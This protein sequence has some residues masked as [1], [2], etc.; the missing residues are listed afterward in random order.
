MV[1]VF[2]GNGVAGYTSLA[3]IDRPTVILG[4]VGQKCGVV[5]RNDGPAWIT[6][7]ALYARRFK[8]PLDVQFLALALEA[9]RLNDVKNKNDLPLIT[10][11][12]LNDVSIAW[13][14]SPQEQ[15][16]IADVVTDVN[17]LIASLER[18][19]AKKQAIKQGA[20]QQLLTGRTRLRGFTIAWERRRV[21]DMGDVLAGKALN[22]KGAGVLRPYLRTK[23]VL[24]G[25]IDLGDVLLMPMTNAEFER[26]R[27]R[28]GDVLLNEG[29]SLEL[30]G[31]CAVYNDEFGAP[32][33]MQNQLLRFRAFPGTCPEFAAHLFRCCQQTGVF[34]A[35]ATK[36]TSVAHLGSSRL[37]NLDLLWPFDRLEQSAIAEVLSDMDGEIAAYQ[38]RLDKAHAVKRGMMQ[39]LLSGHIR[40]PVEEGAG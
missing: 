11:S 28:R 15:R 19:I 16:K 8:R 22:V 5:Y 30:V 34:A 18:M 26:F 29:Q 35:V 36:T 9:A 7:N 33:A 2:G 38:T 12:I 13:P 4:R 10:Q 6:D 14:E 1:P 3:M 20:M 37:S 21:A 32:C 25:R 39:E 40:L 17:D 23:N 31:R 27:I 24:D